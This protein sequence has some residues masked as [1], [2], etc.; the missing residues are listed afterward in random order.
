MIGE[1][2]MQTIN[3]TAW[4]HKVSHNCLHALLEAGY[5]KPRDIAFVR[6]SRLL[7]IPE[8][9]ANDVASMLFALND[10][11]FKAR[12]ISCPPGSFD[13]TREELAERVRKP[14]KEYRLD[15]KPRKLLSLTAIEMIKIASHDMA[16]IPQMVRKKHFMLGKPDPEALLSL[17]SIQKKE[18]CE[19]RWWAASSDAPDA[20]W[21]DQL[22]D[23]EY[24]NQA[25]PSY[26]CCDDLPVIH[27]RKCA[28]KIPV[29]C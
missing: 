24:E 12:N 29:F 19:G 11:V 27:Q 28:R 23:E 6:V 17:P 22:R 8:V 18:P 10:A 20:K 13:L 15:S 14:C 7:R 4:N 9:D 25:D 5:R 3:M 2:S 21:E 26:D 1:T 16:V